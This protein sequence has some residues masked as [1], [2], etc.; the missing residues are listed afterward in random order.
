MG[1]S[2]ATVGKVDS[3]VPPNVPPNGPGAAALLA[4][5]LG[6]FVLGVCA[7]AGDAFPRV[8]RALNL[9]PPTGPLSGVT[10]V[11]IIVWLLAWLALGWRWSGRNVAMHRINW[12]AAALFIGGLLLTFPPFMDLLQG[13]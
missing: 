10:G 1:S 12:I 3:S 9:W 5:G 8:A 4:A 6:G 11:A 2:A 7:L 13:R